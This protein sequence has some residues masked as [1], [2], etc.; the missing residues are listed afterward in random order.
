MRNLWLALMLGAAGCNGDTGHTGGPHDTVDTVDTTVDTD[1]DVPVVCA[2]LGVGD[3]EH[4]TADICDEAP[5]CKSIKGFPVIVDPTVTDGYCVDKSALPKRLGCTEH[6][7]QCDGGDPTWGRP[8]QAPD[9]VC[10]RILGHCQPR[11]FVPCVH[12]L[13][14]TNFCPE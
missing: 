10:F 11:D 7:R 3:A 4:P 1:T 14:V 9:T 13:E 8:P 6:S 2:D 12:G 5:S